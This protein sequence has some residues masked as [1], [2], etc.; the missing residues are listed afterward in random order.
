MSIVAQLGWPP[1]DPVPLD[2]QWFGPVR[3]G[4]CHLG[5]DAGE[6]SGSVPSL[7]SYEVALEACWLRGRLEA[8]QL[9]TAVAGNW[10]VNKLLNTFRHFFFFFF[11]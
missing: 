6:A 5:S 7:S 4:P 3:A 10:D 1:L 8:S 11:K 2:L 9:G